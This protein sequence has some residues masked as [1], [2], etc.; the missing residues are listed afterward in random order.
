MRRAVRARQLHR[1]RRRIRRGL[2]VRQ[3]GPAPE[4]RAGSLP[5]R[6]DEVR[7]E[8]HRRL[9]RQLCHAGVQLRLPRASSAAWS[10][11]ARLAEGIFTRY[12]SVP[13]LDWFWTW[14]PEASSGR[15]DAKDPTFTTVDD[16]AAAATSRPPP[17]PGRVVGPCPIDPSLTRCRRPRGMPY[18]HRP[19][20]GHDPVDPAYKNVT[21]HAKWAIPWMEDDRKFSPHP[22]RCRCV[23]PFS[24][25]ALTCNVLLLST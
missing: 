1:G 18:E 23:Y 4:C 11:D 13:S 12:R 8:R 9:R 24:A 17:H 5:L 22:S 7:G 20:P 15:T 6:R 25:L 10:H 14:T 21:R 16:L 2:P 19:Q 3:R